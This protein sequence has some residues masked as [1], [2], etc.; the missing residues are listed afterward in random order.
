MGN[1]LCLEL[2]KRIRALRKKKQ[3]RIIDLAAHAGLHE[4]YISQ[5][6]RGLKEICVLALG[7]IA[8]ALDTTASDLLK[9]IG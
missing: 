9:G 2:G 1:N 7:S 8:V 4:V 3:W 6:E 5:V